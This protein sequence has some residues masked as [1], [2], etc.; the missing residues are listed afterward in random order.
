MPNDVMKTMWRPEAHQLSEAWHTTS[1]ALLD[2]HQQA[3]TQLLET[4]QG[5]SGEI[6]QLAQTRLQ[7]MIEAWSALAAC[8]NP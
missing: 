4:M 3:L 7:L 1:A 2:G 5:I 6:S 8:R